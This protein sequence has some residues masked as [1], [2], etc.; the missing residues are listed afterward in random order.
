MLWA[1]HVENAR[2]AASSRG[3]VIAYVRVSSD[4]RQSPNPDRKGR[5]ANDVTMR[6]N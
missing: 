2:R 4:A 3:A 1:N 6:S 5:S